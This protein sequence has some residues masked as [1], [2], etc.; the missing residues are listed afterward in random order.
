MQHTFTM[1]ADVRCEDGKAGTVGGLLINPNRNEVDYVIMNPGLLGG[2]EYYVPRGRIGRATG[3]E[4][5]VPCNQADLEELPRPTL[6]PEQGTVLDNLGDFCIARKDTPVRDEA[7]GRLG[8]LHGVAVDG[9]DFV[10]R[11]IMLDGAPDT[12]VPIVRVA[13]YSDDDE[14]ALV[15]SL[16]RETVA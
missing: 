4:V 15:V 10:V 13:R 2:R 16:A 11:A 5:I 7:G 8:L 3:G 1:G 14:G 12:A 9:E 6:L